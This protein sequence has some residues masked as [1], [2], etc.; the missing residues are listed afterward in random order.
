M[1]LVP[2]EIQRLFRK[3]RDLFIQAVYPNAGI[4]R[5]KFFRFIANGVRSG[6]FDFSD[7]VA[8][9]DLNEFYHS[10][11][12]LRDDYVEEHYTDILERIKESATKEELK[13]LPDFL[14]DYFAAKQR[15]ANE[16]SD[17]ESFT[18]LPPD[19]RT[20]LFESS[21]PLREKMLER[22]IPIV[23]TELG[24]DDERIKQLAE[25]TQKKREFYH[26]VLFPRINESARAVGLQ[27]DEKLIWRKAD[28]LIKSVAAG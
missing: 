12:K 9:D 19:I 10:F 14:F 27:F 7:L 24:F 3:V 1:T 28:E 8:Q 13:E 25:D 6:D 4:L 17:I 23:L 2:K 16:L 20:E 5:G 15:L 18:K 11:R 22:L 26:D 21:K